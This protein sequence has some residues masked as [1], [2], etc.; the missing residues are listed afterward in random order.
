MLL[1]RPPAKC[2]RCKNK[3]EDIKELLF[4]RLSNLH[5]AAGIVIIAKTTHPVLLKDP[6]FVNH[7]LQLYHLK[8]YLG[9]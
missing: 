4:R 7:L 2:H 8:N 3:I 1:E 5:Q 9:I 6:S